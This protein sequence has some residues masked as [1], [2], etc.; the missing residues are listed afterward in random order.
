MLKVK[1]FI[2]KSKILRWIPAIL[3]MALIF[4]MSSKTGGE[5]KAQSAG[6]ARIILD[7]FGID[8]SKIRPLIVILRKS[9]H[10]FLFA[11]LGV[12][13]FYA[14]CG[15]KIKSAKIFLVCASLCLSYAISDEFHQSLV[16][17]RGPLVTDVFIDFSGSLFGSGIAML[18]Y[19]LK[20][21][22]NF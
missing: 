1:K 8:E 17:G 19:K 21:T 12:S 16:P 14:L 3:V 4:Y 18:I 2:L 6:I 15:Y 20:K 11:A 22:D 13:V 5:S 10:F 7:F 9:A